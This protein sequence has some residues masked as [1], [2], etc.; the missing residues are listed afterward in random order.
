VRPGQRIVARGADV[1]KI[2]DVEKFRRLRASE[3]GHIDILVN[4]AGVYGPKGVIEDVDWREW[5]R[6]IDINLYGSILMCRAVLPTFKARKGG[7]IIQLSG[8]GATGP[9]PRLSAY[10]V[11]KA[12]IVRFVETLAEEV[13]NDGIDV[14]AIAPGAL[15][16]RLLEEIWM[17]ARKGRRIVLRARAQAKAVRRHPSPE[18][19]GAGGVPGLVA[20]QRIT[21]KLISA[22]WDPWVFAAEHLDDLASSDIY[23]LRR[24]LPKDRGKTWGN[25]S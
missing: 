18:G 3:F 15:N 25:D 23:T 6:A 9:L 2:G 10:A 22:A 24:I 11:S 20:K 12:A 21:G 5:A 17:P 1:S 16:T 4:N 14:N 13:R 8:G 19:R 7:K